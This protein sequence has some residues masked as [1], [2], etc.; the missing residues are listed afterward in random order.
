MLG[1]IRAEKANACPKLMFIYVGVNRHQISDMV[2]T[3]ATHSFVVKSIIPTLGLSMVRH[4]SHIKVV[5]SQ[6]QAMQGMAYGV[7]A[8]IEKW[9][10]KLDLM[11]VPL[12]NFNLI[13]S[14]DFLVVTKV[15]TLPHLFRLLI[16]DEKKPCFVIGHSV[17][18]DTEVH[19][20]KMKM[21]YA[22]QL[23]HGWTKGQM[24]YLAAL[25]DLG[26]E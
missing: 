11:I 20:Q 26:P 21:V 25:I 1:A 22:M 12:D 17:P 6:A 2:D 5:N 24:T 3:G 9:D 16:G 19:K 23:A 8:S 7:Q 13:L 15:G 4:P 18:S 10:G 14:N